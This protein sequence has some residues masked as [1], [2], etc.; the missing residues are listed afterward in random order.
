MCGRYT[1]EWLDSLITVSLNPDKTDVATITDEQIKSAI[2][3]IA[4]EKDKQ[5]SLLKSQV[6][7]LMK[8]KQIELLLK[9][10]HSALIV[11]LDQALQNHTYAPGKKPALKILTGE[12]IT[13]LG[14]LLSFIEVRFST[15]LCLDERV[16]V[17]NH[18]VTQKEI[19]QRVDRL[20]TRL[21]RQV[22]DDRIT[23]IVLDCL[24][25]FINPPKEGYPVTFQ[26][27]AYIKELLKGLETLEGSKKKDQIYSSMDE[28]LISLN[29]NCR[30][31]ISYFTQNIDAKINDYE[32]ISDKM[33]GLLFYFKAFNQLYRKSDI[34]LHPGQ[35]NLKDE[36]GNWFMQ[37]ISYLEKKLQWSLIPQ[38]DKTEHQKKPVEKE[39]NKVLC[40]L[41]TDQM[42]LII[43]AAD[44]LRILKARSMNEVFKTIVPFLSTPYKENLSYDSMR[45]KSY[46]AEDR[47][48][49]IAIETLEKVI[50]KVR[51]Y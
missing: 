5:Q 36:L 46:V 20:K 51:E 15:Y 1:L 40:I 42:S 29:F 2:S 11:L 18:A 12:L 43:R 31:Y 21:P 39:K 6:F 3:R 49:K 7:G 33:V 23:T 35:V 27:V 19:E 30:D 24:Y 8:E 38:K 32:S 9:Q 17:T 10:Y 14:E 13:C 22:A 44:E 26:A 34:A 48:K 16:P 4:E 28:L 50:E 25:S 45:S 47:D 37:E 41:S